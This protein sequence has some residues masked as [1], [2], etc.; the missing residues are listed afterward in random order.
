[1]ERE[2][3]REKKRGRERGRERERKW[4]E[5]ESKVPLLNARSTE[6]PFPSLTKAVS[7]LKRRPVA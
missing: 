3:E 2:R 4:R 6:R 1:M 5:R 7:L